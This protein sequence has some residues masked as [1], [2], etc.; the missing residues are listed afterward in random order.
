M[1]R[2]TDFLERHKSLIA[3]IKLKTNLHHFLIIEILINY[4]T[5]YIILLILFL[6]YSFVLYL[7]M[8]R[9]PTNKR[10]IFL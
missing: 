6:N 2:L 3:A 7:S 8:P 1:K 4:Y 9:V 10:N 5:E